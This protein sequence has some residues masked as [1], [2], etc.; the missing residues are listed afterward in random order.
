MGNVGFRI[1][2]EISS[3]LIKFRLDFIQSIL[4]IIFFR[5]FTFDNKDGIFYELKI[6]DVTERFMDNDRLTLI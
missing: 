2:N 1:S 3:E 5:D 4:K 6:N